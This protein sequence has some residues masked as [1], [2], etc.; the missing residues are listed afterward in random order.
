MIESLKWRIA[1][2]ESLVKRMNEKQDFTVKKEIFTFLCNECNL[3]DISFKGNL[4]ICKFDM[5]K[6]YRRM[7]SRV[8]SRYKDILKSYREK[9]CKL[10]CNMESQE[11]SIEVDGEIQRVSKNIVPQQGDTIALDK[12]NYKLLLS[13]ISKAIERILDRKVELLVNGDKWSKKWDFTNS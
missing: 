4:A 10:I 7:R 6:F 8:L 12:K 13:C 5:A 11:W 1:K 3:T 2:L 9:Q